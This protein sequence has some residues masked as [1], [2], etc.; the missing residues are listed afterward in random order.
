MLI[1]M[2]E[3]TVAAVVAPALV[4]ALE[5]GVLRT[6]LFRDPRYWIALAI[7]LAFQ[8]PVDGW[9]TGGH[10][11]VVAYDPGAV[12]G[13]RLP[14]N[15]PVE[16]FGFGFTLVTLTLLLWRWRLRRLESDG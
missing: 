6:G 7:A 5:L 14:M 4:V 3:Y 16:D 9:L 10:P 1:A 15:I 11:P 2:P 8:I 12:T 13:V